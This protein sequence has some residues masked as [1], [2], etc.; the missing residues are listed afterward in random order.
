MKNLLFLLLFIPAISS[1]QIVFQHGFGKV[2][3]AGSSSG[4]GIT[5]PVDASLENIYPYVIQNVNFDATRPNKRDTISQN[6][7]FYMNNLPSTGSGTVTFVLTGSWL[8]QV[9]GAI[10]TPLPTSGGVYVR[11]YNYSGSGVN[12]P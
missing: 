2:V 4:G 3:I 5:V 8:L 6:T 1:A 11:A 7:T 12:W 9:N 10:G